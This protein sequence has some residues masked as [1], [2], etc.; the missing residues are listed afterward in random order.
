[1]YSLYCVF[2]LLYERTNDC[3]D[4][5]TLAFPLGEQGTRQYFTQY[6]RRK[7]FQSSVTGFLATWSFVLRKSNKTN[8][9]CFVVQLSGRAHGKGHCY[10]SEAIVFKFYSSP[11]KVCWLQKNV[12]RS[13]ARESAE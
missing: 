6:Y 5:K 3:G 9:R 13:D 4:H 1:M 10:I 7:T 8:F 11:S 2:P 12:V